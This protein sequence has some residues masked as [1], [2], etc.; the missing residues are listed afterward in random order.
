MQFRNVI[1]YFYYF[2]RSSKCFF[3]YCN[4]SN[5]CTIFYRNKYHIIVFNYVEKKKKAFVPNISMPYT[6]GRRSS[7]LM[8]NFRGEEEKMYFSN[9]RIN[10]LITMRVAVRRILTRGKRTSGRPDCTRRPATA[11]T[12]AAWWPGTRRAGTAV[13]SGDGDDGDGAPLRRVSGSRCPTWCRRRRALWYG[14]VAPGDGELFRIRGDVAR[15]PSSRPGE[16]SEFFARTTDECQ[17]NNAAACAT[18]TVRPYNSAK[19]QTNKQKNKRKT[20]NSAVAAVVR[21]SVRG[22]GTRLSCGLF[23]RTRGKNKKKNYNTDQ[24]LTRKWRGKKKNQIK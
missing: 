22:Y 17:R 21:V 9:R 2:T 10:V 24:L 16:P 4:F 3:F 12:R 23:G 6:H 7:P 1:N 11:S 14:R 20:K 5:A 19:K 15:A 13:F 18:V 8:I